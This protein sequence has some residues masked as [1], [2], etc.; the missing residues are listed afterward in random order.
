M[1][2]MKTGLIAGT[3]LAISMIAFAQANSAEV[4]KV[5][6]SYT[7]GQFAFKLIND[8]WAPKLKAMTGGE[9]GIEVLPTPFGWCRIARPRMPSP[10]AFWTA[11]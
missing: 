8:V 1:K 11:T 4:L 2:W 5:Q 7:A 10:A 3:A 9:I 6:G